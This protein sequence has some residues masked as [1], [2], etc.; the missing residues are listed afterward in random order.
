MAAANRLGLAS[1][2]ADNVDLVAELVVVCVEACNVGVELVDRLLKHFH[3]L[4]DG[5]VIVGFLHSPRRSPDFNFKIFDRMRA[6]GTVL[7][8]AVQ[9]G[10]EQNSPLCSVW[11]EQIMTRAD[12]TSPVQVP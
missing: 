1:L 4:A 8:S 7:C 3:L 12:Q 10:K 11:P 9:C 2:R 5:H 6:L